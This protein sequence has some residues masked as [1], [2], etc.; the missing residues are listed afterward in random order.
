M[1]IGTCVARA[2]CVIVTVGVAGA[3]DPAR[4]G[5]TNLHSGLE[6]LDARRTTAVGST[7]ARGGTG[8]VLERLSKGHVRVWRAIER[9]VSASNPSGEPRS[10]TLRRLWEWA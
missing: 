7:P 4:A 8:F 9:V 2:F 5:E 1:S 6:P 3:L 10:P